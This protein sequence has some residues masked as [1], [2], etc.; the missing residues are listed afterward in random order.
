M[1]LRVV[2]NKL[3][4]R[5]LPVKK[6]PDI[7]GQVTHQHLQLPWCMHDAA[8]GACRVGRVYGHLLLCL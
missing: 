6:P 8:D 1:H 5:T 2:H 4:G 7:A 3:D